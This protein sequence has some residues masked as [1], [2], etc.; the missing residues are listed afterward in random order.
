MSQTGRLFF[1]LRVTEILKL[2]NKMTFGVGEKKD[3]VE[4]KNIKVNK[5][6][7]LNF[8]YVRS[9]RIILCAM[10]TEVW[11]MVQRYRRLLI[12]LC[13][14]ALKMFQKFIRSAETFLSNIMKVFHF[15]FL[16]LLGLSSG[17]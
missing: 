11:N 1:S 15:G 17:E 12:F 2:L 5:K 13:L 6:K 9:R 7:L 3:F 14:I 8:Y 4:I 10:F 16:H